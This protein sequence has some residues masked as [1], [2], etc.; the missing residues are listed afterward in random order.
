MERN[1]MLNLGLIVG[2]L[3][4]VVFIGGCAPAGAGE[5]GSILPMIIFLVLIFGIMYL[6]MIRDD[7]ES[8][9]R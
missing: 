9:Q 1:K 2:L 3:I 4:R 7:Y 8:S 6:V 5:E